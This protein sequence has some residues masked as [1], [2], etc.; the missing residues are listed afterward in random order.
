M[1]TNE[2]HL[3]Y[4]LKADNNTIQNIIDNIDDYYISWEKL[5]LLPNGKYK[6]RQ[7]NTTKPEFKKIQKRIY[8]FLLE[9]VNIS[10][11]S[12]GGIRKK[13]NVINAKQHQGNK[14]IFT[15]DLKKF[16][17]SI[18]HNQVF[19]LFLELG[20]TPKISRILTQ[21]TTY[22]SELPQG[23]PTSTLLANLVFK[24]TGDKIFDFA[25]CNNMK[26]TTFVDDLTI[27]SKIDFKD[28]I[29]A[30]IKIITNDGYKI[31]R[32]KTNYKTKNP[33]ITGVVC[34]NNKLKLE[35]SVYKRIAKL[36]KQKDKNSNDTTVTNKYNG[37]LLY[38][39]KIENAN[40]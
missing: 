35:N 31:S 1:I 28:K 36:K 17:P 27:S 40:N 13:D 14:Y 6:T 22:K 10:D 5:K 25:K 21:L 33:T 26:F 11:Y 2:K 7:L 39:K 20:V 8:N 38:R 3:Y 30:I 24:K 29:P 37:L 32:K 34:Q 12:Y 4:I 16:F 15:T 9:K 23:V 19:Q 18:S